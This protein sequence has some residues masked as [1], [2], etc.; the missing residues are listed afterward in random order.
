MK[1]TILLLT[2]F[3]VATL[4]A[5]EI[6]ITLDQDSLTPLKSSW[7][8]YFGTHYK[9]T[10]EGSGSIWNTVRS[11]GGPHI[12][13]HDNPDSPTLKGPFTG[14]ELHLS[15]SDIKG[16]RA[17][18]GADVLIP[19]IVKNDLTAIYIMSGLVSPTLEP[20]DKDLAYW[21]LRR[22]YETFPAANTNLVW[23]MGNE[24]VSG[25]FDPRGIWKNIQNKSAKGKGREDNFFGY[26]LAW[27]ENYYVNDFLAPAIE[28][29]ERAA[30]DVYKDPRAIRIALGSMN[31]YNRENITFLRNV[32]DRKFESVQAP[33]LNGEPVWKHIDLI[34]VHYMTGSTRTIETLQGY[35]D[36][37]V[38]TGKVRGIWITE[39]HGNGG[40]GPVTILDRGLRYLDWIARN[41]LDAE[42]TRL[43]W[44]GE[45]QKDPGGQGTEATRLLGAF[46][47]N[48]QILFSR[49]KQKEMTVATMANASDENNLNRIMV[50]VI[51]SSEG[52]QNVDSLRLK[53]PGK[54]ISKNWAAKAVIYSVEVPSKTSV[55]PVEKKDNMLEVNINAE[56]KGALLVMLTTGA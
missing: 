21:A 26:D 17:V 31:P 39:D 2:A 51:P 53:L 8:E 44:W 20:F 56:V 35:L 7:A 28:A 34:T 11:Y 13:I 49:N 46:W 16:K 55:A 1:H 10:P 54:A 29:T 38:R 32:M 52:H 19:D 14:R 33:T 47:K 40:K 50:A 23:E 30:L 43:C 24:V 18:K 25:H 3:N 36:N 41:G 27:K 45:A 12:S 5:A 4:L 6:T 22:I 37:Y 15:L 9:S 42:Q 48:Q